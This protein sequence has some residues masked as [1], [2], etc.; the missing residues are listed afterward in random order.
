MLRSNDT[1]SQWLLYKCFDKLVRVVFSYSWYLYVGLALLEVGLIV[2][3]YG[4]EDS[5]Y[6]VYT[7][8]FLLLVPFI[9]IFWYVFGRLVSGQSY[10]CVYTSA[11]YGSSTLLPPTTNQLVT[12]LKLK[13]SSPYQNGKAH[14]RL[15]C[16]Q[17]IDV[18]TSY[19]WLCP[20]KVIK[21]HRFPPLLIQEIQG[22]VDGVNEVSCRTTL[23]LYDLLAVYF[24]ADKFA[25][26]TC[27]GIKKP[28]VTNGKSTSP[29]FFLA[30]NMDWIPFGMAQNSLILEY[31][32]G[33]RLLTA[34]GLIGGV[35]GWK[36]DLRFAMNVCPDPH[37]YYSSALPSVLYNRMLIDSCR[38]SEDVLKYIDTAPDP[39]NAFHLTIMD[40]KDLFSVAFFQ[41]FELNNP[42]KHYIRRPTVGHPLI[43][44]NDSSC[45][46]STFL[47]SDRQHRLAQQPLNT[48]THLKKGLQTCQSWITVHSVIFDSNPS[49]SPLISI[50]NGFAADY[51]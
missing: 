37:V 1:T 15:L 17:V 29:G 24:V 48:L 39:R 45:G 38:T 33:L 3:K 32:N 6:S 2:E 47:S 36:D 5:P 7:S 26:C 22:I 18:V 43:V 35:T 21:T 28:L 12:I 51:L 50:R 4:E 44:V 19:G 31:D 9:G 13:E 16:K 40:E 46:A 42:T 20:V 49:V 25:A 27:I 8:I 10:P 14:G 30:R 11:S 41:F 23:T 34:P